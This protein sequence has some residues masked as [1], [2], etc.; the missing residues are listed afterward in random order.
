[1]RRVTAMFILILGLGISGCTHDGPTTPEQL[2]GV[3]MIPA[4][5]EYAP[6]VTEIPVVWRNDTD[7]DLIYGEPFYI[8]KKEGTTWTTVDVGELMFILPAYTISPH[9]QSDH[10]YIVT[11]YTSMFTSGTYRIAATYSLVL[12]SGDSTTYIAYAEFRIT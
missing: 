8:E 1:M 6:D 11:A 3:S 7:N 12:S 4:Q 5:Q 10:T 9:S 2:P